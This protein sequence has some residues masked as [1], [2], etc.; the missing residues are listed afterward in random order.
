LWVVENV[1]QL[2]AEDLLRLQQVARYAAARLV[3]VADKQESSLSWGN[4]PTLLAEQG[5]TTFNF[6]KSTAALNPS[7][8]AASEK[9]IQGKVDDAL[10]II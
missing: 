10:N 2:G 1:S 4:V 7:I 3:L 5:I 8:N 9:L 6:D